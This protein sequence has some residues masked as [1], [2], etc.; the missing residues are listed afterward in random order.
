M[1]SAQPVWRDKLMNV[2]KYIPGFQSIEH[3]QISEQPVCSLAHLW[4]DLLRINANLK[5]RCNLDKAQCIEDIN[6][7]IYIWSKRIGLE[8][9]A[10]HDHSKVLRLQ[11]RERSPTIY[12]LTLTCSSIGSL[13]MTTASCS[14]LK[15]KTR[16][17]CGVSLVLLTFLDGLEC[18]LNN[19]P[20]GESRT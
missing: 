11:L 14:P 16:A 2:Q 15:T 8:D 9:S 3:D 7:S 20:A 10:M 18:F 6:K 5:V 4:L 19:L 17:C 13:T 1:C 12:L